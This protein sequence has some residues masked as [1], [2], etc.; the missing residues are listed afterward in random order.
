M[1]S[2][3]VEIVC[4]AVSPLTDAEFESAA[5]SVALELFS[6]EEGKGARFAATP[7]GRRLTFGF[8]VEATNKR[9]G[10]RQGSATARTALHA[11]G[12]AT[13]G[14]QTDFEEVE[15]KATRESEV[16]ETSQTGGAVR[17]SLESWLTPTP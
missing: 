14:W 11:A 3:D 9:D 1:P 6:L 2:Y 13:P 10:L 17:V 16:I 5:D 7:R 8:M 15:S 4:E 12:G